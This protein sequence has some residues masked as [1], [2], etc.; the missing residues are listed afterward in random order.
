MVFQVG[1]LDNRSFTLAADLQMSRRIRRTPFTESVERCGVTGFTV[2]NHTLLPKAFSYSIEDDF[3]HLR[4]SVQ[5]WDVGCQRQV[6]LKGSDAQYLLQKMTPRNIQKA[7]VG[8]CLY[9]PLTTDEGKIINDPIMLKLGEDHF[10]LSIADSDVLLWVKALAIGENLRVSVIEPAVWPLAI[11]GPSSAE[12]LCNLFGA[13]ISELGFF[14]FD[15]FSFKG[16]RQLI[17]RSGYSSQQGYEIYLNDY[18]LGKDLWDSIFLAGQDYDIRPGTP[19]L[20][21]RIEA[22]L[23]SF[24]N[25]MTMENSPLECGLGRYC[26]LEDEIDFLGKG[27]LCKEKKEGSARQ[28]RGVVFSGR[29][30]SVCTSPWPLFVDDK[31]VGQITSGIFNPSLKVNTGLALIEKGYWDSGNEVEVALTKND[32]RVGYICALPFT[33]TEN[34]ETLL[35]CKSNK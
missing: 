30:G 15:Y 9:L 27:V 31:K 33:K 22:G 16:T 21:D 26:S 2:V 29:S 6:E 25:D 4:N 20:I 28:L 12:L 7:K 34:Y 8:D 18:F 17:A 13:K 32:T 35:K 3:F 14:K 5:I 19:N 23:I 10:W 11:Q 1:F 24:G